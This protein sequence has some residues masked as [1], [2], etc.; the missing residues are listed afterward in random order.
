MDPIS[1]YRRLESLSGT[2]LS[3][4]NPFRKLV[5]L[6]YEEENCT[7]FQKTG[8]NFFRGRGKAE[9]VFFFFLQRNFFYLLGFYLSH[10]NNTLKIFLQVKNK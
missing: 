4:G 7:L 1:P 8:E 5:Q 3:Q 10:V 6:L 9:S 2:S